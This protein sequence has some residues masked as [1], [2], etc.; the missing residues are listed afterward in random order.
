MTASGY[1]GQLVSPQRSEVYL[2][3]EHSIPVY[4]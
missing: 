4:L 1:E 3:Y 2:A